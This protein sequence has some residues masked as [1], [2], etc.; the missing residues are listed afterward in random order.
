MFIAHVP[1][2]YLVARLSNASKLFKIGILIGS[3]AL[4]L[5]ILWFYFV[6]GGTIH[7]HEYLTH[8]P[9]FWT[10]LLVIVGFF[11]LPFLQGLGVGGLVH[12][13]LDSIVGRITWAWPLSSK[14]FTLVEVPATQSHWI[15]SFLTHWTFFV[16]IAITLCAI[17]VFVYSRRLKP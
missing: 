8:R 4:D 15:L 6:D 13:L 16:E 10:L 12:M 17:A 11:R 7:H 5:D 2:G 14:T 3:V 9:I 1:S